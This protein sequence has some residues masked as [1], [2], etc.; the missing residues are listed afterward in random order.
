MKPICQARNAY[1]RW[2]ARG[3]VG[4]AVLCERLGAFRIRTEDTLYYEFPDGSLLLLGS[5]RRNVSA[6]AVQE[7][8]RLG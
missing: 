4:A 6:V 8:P 1:D 3:C 2:A 5:G 7:P